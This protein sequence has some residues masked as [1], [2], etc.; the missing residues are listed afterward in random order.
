MPETAN[1]WF[2]R[3]DREIL[4]LAIPN[5]LSNLSVPLLSSVDTVLMGQ[6]SA[7]HLGAVGIGTMIFNFL[8]WN[9]GF[10]RMG[11]TGMTAQAFGREDPREVM[12]TLGR[13]LLLGLCIALVILLLRPWIADLAMDLMQ[14]NLD[15]RDLVATYFHIR[16]WA[17]PATLGLYVILGWYFGLQ[18]AIYPLILTVFL[19]IINMLLS[20]Y[21]VQELDWGVAGVA[22]GTVWAQYTGFSLGLAMLL[23]RYR[24]YLS[25]F[26]FWPLF[27]IAPFRRFLHVNGDIFLRTLC[28]T[29]AY[30]FFFSQSSARGEEILAINTLLY[31]FLIWMAYGTDGFAFAAESLVGKYKGAADSSR[32]DQAIR[33]SLIW[34]GGFAVLLA[35]TYILL[36]P[37]ILNLFTDEEAVVAAAM[38][39]LWWA[40]PM[41]LIAFQSFM[42]DGIFVGLTASRAMRNSMAMAL[43]LF[44]LAYYLC[45]P[46]GNHGLW[47]AFAIFY[48]S[49]GLIQWGFFRWKGVVLR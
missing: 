26:R 37:A 16:I 5:I 43:V 41:P 20:I 7:A 44:L 24:E 1:R 3:I 8:Y 10:L 25:W 22:W 23:W 47:L 21:L 14:V 4:N 15:Q 38:P 31:Q 45:L 17:I 13:A 9:F 36:G 40:A 27:E 12:L 48:V 19:N 35:T 42:W 29:F 46:L 28:L 6:L 2:G 18:N 32:L 39:Y 30:A 34:G 49:R 33:K 11:T